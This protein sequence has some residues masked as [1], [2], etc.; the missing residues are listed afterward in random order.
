MGKSNEITAIPKLLNQLDITGAVIT[1][2]A[3]GCQTKV[4][5]QIIDQ[6][7]DY[8]LS[9]KGNQGT[10][11]D[12]VKLFFE[13]SNTC[14][15]V[16]HESYDRGHGRIETRIVFNIGWLKELHCS[17]LKAE[18][19]LCLPTEAQWEYVCRVGTTTLFSFG[20]PVVG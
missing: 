2:D 14:P 17:G 8:T 9:L 1:M 15:E 3:M 10:L 20:E 18:L 5:K 11:H 16:G 7:G 6:S 13:S 4:A 19:K 12:D